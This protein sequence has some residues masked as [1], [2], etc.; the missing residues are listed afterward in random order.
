MPRPARQLPVAASL[1]EVLKLV[2]DPRARRG[3]RHGLP[4][5]VAVA[6]AAVM[7]GA[8]SFAAIGQWG[9][10]LTGAQLAELGLSRGVAPDASTFRKVLGR[11]DAPVLDQL[12]GALVWTRTR[13]AGGR[14]VIAI[15]GRT[16]RGARTADRPAPH[17]VSAYDHAT[18]TVLGQLAIAAKSDEIPAVRTLLAG[19]DLAGVAVTA[20]AMHTQADTATAITGAHG[21]YVFTVKANQPSLHAACKHLPWRDVAAHASVITSHG[22]RVRA[23]S[24]SSPPRPG[25]PSP[26]PLR[27]LRSAGP[28]PGRERRPSRPST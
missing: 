6:L 15:D 12:A 28:P 18:G 11:L 16:V 9:S 26:A 14:R 23:P 7:A 19:M 13:V 8:R 20:D 10:E 1:V 24:R 3:I 21:D 2:P 5:I 25:S 17:L 27:S 22:R 4:G